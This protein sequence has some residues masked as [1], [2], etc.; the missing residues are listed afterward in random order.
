MPCYV[1]VEI[2]SDTKKQKKM[3]RELISKDLWKEL[4]DVV[5]VLTSRRIRRLP[6][7]LTIWNSPHVIGW[8]EGQFTFNCV[9]S[10]VELI[11]DYKYLIASMKSDICG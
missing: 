6:K 8:F 3:Y 7:G 9:H 5:R 4:T 2:K 1:G 11:L 10:S